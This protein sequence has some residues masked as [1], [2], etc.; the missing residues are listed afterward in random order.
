M[1]GLPK[2]APF[3]ASRSDQPTPIMNR[4]MAAALGLCRTP[5]TTAEALSLFHSRQPGK[6]QPSMASRPATKPS[7]FAHL[8]GSSP[9]AP[10]LR[11]GGNVPSGTLAVKGAK[12]QRTFA[13]AADAAA[14]VLQ[15]GGRH[16]AR[17]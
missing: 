13:T 4:R 3:H 7:R 6:G 16:G 10:A 14:H 8:A 9:I 1:S 2:A 17:R 11:N 5:R 15:A 12:P